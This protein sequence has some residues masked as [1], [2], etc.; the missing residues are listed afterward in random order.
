MADDDH[1]V[2][3]P[4]RGV[5]GSSRD[6]ARDE[7]LNLVDEAPEGRRKVARAD[8]VGLPDPQVDVEEPKEDRRHDQDRLPQPGPPGTGLA[9]VGWAQR[10]APDDAGFLAE[11]GDSHDERASHVRPDSM[12]GHSKGDDKK[13]RAVDEGAPD[14]EDE[15]EREDGGGPPEGVLPGVL[16]EPPQQ[17]RGQDVPAEDVLQRIE[18]HDPRGISPTHEPGGPLEQ[19]PPCPIGKAIHGPPDNRIRQPGVHRRSAHTTGSRIPAN[20][21]SRSGSRP[22]PREVAGVLLGSKLDKIGEPLPRKVE[23]RDVPREERDHDP[24]HEPPPSIALA[25]EK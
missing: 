21:A 11:P 13:A 25:F 22:A 2:Q 23:K 4:D 17:E 7:V 14:A 3:P 16:R 15:P 8:V 10:H 1:E 6:D 19:N 9:Q 5:V 24:A 12:Q 20:C 18:I